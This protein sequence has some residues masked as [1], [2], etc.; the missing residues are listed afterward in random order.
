[1]F[2]F[3]FLTGYANAGEQAKCAAVLSTEVQTY[4][5]EARHV[6]DI[7][8]PNGEAIKSIKIGDRFAWNPSLDQGRNEITLRPQ[9]SGSLTNLI[10]TTTGANGEEQRYEVRL[11]SIEPEPRTGVRLPTKQASL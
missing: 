1:M 11:V 9:Y 10:V 7:C 3:A 5:V 2:C 6:T 4:A 8:T